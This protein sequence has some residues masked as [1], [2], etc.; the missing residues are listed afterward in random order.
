MLNWNVQSGV[1]SCRETLLWERYGHFLEIQIETLLSVPKSFYS[2]G[3]R[4]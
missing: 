3:Q 1:E 2:L 4:N